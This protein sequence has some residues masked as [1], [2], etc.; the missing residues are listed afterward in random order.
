MRIATCFLMITF[1]AIAPSG[2][3]ELPADL[4]ARLTKTIREHCPNAQIAAKGESFSAKSGTTMFTFHHRQKG[5]KEFET[6]YQEE[7]P[8]DRGFILSVLLVE[9]PYQGQLLT[10]AEVKGPHFPTFVDAVPTENGK[11]HY[12]VHFSYGVGIDPKLKEA[13]FAALPKSK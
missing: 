3:E 11:T 4:V 7:G 8:D 9:G 10:P 6:T 2:A 1:G 5:D 12:Y 13:V